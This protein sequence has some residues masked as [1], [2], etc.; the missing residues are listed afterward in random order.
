[1]VAQHDAG[2]SVVPPSSCWATTDAARPCSWRIRVTRVFISTL[3][4]CSSTRSRQ[5][6]HI[7]PGPSRGY[8]NSSIREVMSFWLRFGRMALTTAE[9]RD[10][11]FTRWAAQSAGISAGGW[12]HTFSV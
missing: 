12:P 6:S 3:V 9:A 8:W 4:P 7:I 1:V 5:R 11:F 10:R 2:Y